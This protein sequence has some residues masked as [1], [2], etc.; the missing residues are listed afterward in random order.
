[1]RYITFN[2]DAALNVNQKMMG[3]GVV[4]RDANGVVVAAL[5]RFYPHI[6]DPAVAEAIAAWQAM[7]Y[8]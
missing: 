2:W 3:V 1:M 8:V 4:E 5:A 7:G 6:E